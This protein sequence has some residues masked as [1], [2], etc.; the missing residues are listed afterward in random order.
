MVLKFADF[1]IMV[2]LPA[3]LNPRP[4]SWA[5]TVLLEPK[6][7]DS[8]VLPRSYSC[9]LWI[10]LAIVPCMR[11]LCLALCNVAE[12]LITPAEP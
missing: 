11:F 8:E 4:L 2:I 3:L 7:M 9:L 12:V 6:P 10:V 5:L 1:Y